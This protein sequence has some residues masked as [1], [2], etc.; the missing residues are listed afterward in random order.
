MTVALV[1]GGETALAATIDCSGGVCE[2]TDRADTLYGSPGQDVMYGLGGIDTLYAN[3][4]ENRLYGNTDEDREFCQPL[5]E[6]L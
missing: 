2:G 3:G 4:G 5:A 1:V 6:I